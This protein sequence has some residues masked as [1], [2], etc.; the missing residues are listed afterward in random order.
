M[1]CDNCGISVL[2]CSGQCKNKEKIEEY[3]DII[4]DYGKEFTVSKI[5]MDF[6]RAMQIEKVLIPH[7]KEEILKLI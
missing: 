7:W 6:E 2:S 1:K 3:L 4:I 5:S